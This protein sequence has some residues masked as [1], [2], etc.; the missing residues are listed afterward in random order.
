MQRPRPSVRGGAGLAEHRSSSDARQRRHRAWTTGRRDVARMVPAACEQILDIGCSDGSL[1]ATLKDARTR[2][3]WGIEVEPDLARIASSRLDYVIEGDAL[4]VLRSGQLGDAQFDCVVLA[5]VLE[6]TVDPWAILAEATKVARSGGWV[7]VSLPNV[8]H[9]STHLALLR[10]RWP[11][12]PRGIH[13]ETHLRFFAINNVKDLFAGAGLE[14]VQ[15]HRKL[16]LIEHPHRLNRYAALGWVWPSLFTFQFI[17]LG[18]VPVG[19]S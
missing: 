11:Y 12:R 17:G 8:A 6:H 5:D 7:V 16:R 3:V 15:L 10:G 4:D 13:D 14:L 1:G 9:W 18:R 2:R 19:S